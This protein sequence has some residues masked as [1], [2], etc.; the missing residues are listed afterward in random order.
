MARSN[1]PF[2]IAM[3]LGDAVLVVGL[4][5]VVP[6]AERRDDGRACFVGGRPLGREATLGVALAPPCCWASSLVVAAIRV[7]AAGLH[8]VPSNP[9]AAR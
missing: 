1:A 9:H 6:A 4:I 2:V 3:S 5:V 7:V 8:N